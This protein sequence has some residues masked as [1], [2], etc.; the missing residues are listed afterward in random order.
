MPV[1]TENQPPASP[2]SDGN[3]DHSLTQSHSRSL[4]NGKHS[5]VH[6]YRYAVSGAVLSM[7]GTDEE[8]GAAG[9]SM[10]RLKAFALAECRAPGSKDLVRSD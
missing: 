10:E 8:G 9:I 3:D 1:E 5:H 7:I 2:A 4:A 6:T